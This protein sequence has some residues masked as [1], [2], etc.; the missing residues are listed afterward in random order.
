M[1]R[2][3]L[4]LTLVGAVAAKAQQ[5]SGPVEIQSNLDPK[6]LKLRSGYCPLDGT[7]GEPVG[8]IVTGEILARMTNYAVDPTNGFTTTLQAMLRCPHCG[9]LFTKTDQ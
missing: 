8:V 2:R 6:D 9:T 4:F 3:S 5:R 7:K 1:F